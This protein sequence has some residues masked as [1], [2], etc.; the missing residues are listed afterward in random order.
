MEDIETIDSLSFCLLT[1]ADARELHT[2]QYEGDY[3]VYSPEPQ[4]D[5]GV[6]PGLLDARSPYYVARDSAGAMI[7]FAC[8]GSAACV[9]DAL[10]VTLYPHQP[11]VLPIGLGL[12]PDLTGRGLGVP[13][14]HAIL[15]FARQQFAPRMFA[16]YVL[17]W[18]VRALLVYARAGFEQ[19]G[20]VA[21]AS[22][23]G[24]LLY[25]EMRRAA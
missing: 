6:D 24:P 19:V 23:V 7:G 25:I 13:F 18:N 2:W 1:S 10:P 5:G 21:V 16:L 17:N 15:A 12:R 4:P 20:T 11:G 9:Q 14:V 3:A 8:F 22:A